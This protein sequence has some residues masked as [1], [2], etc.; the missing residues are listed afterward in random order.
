MAAAKEHK[1]IYNV[2]DVPVPYDVSCRMS[3]VMVPMRDGVKLHTVIYF[4]PDFDGKPLPA[5][6]VRS[7][8]TR[9]TYFEL[10]DADCLKH[11]AI[12][13]L[14]A[15]RGTGW[16]EGVFDPAEADTEMNDAADLLEYLSAQNFFNGNCVMRGASYP[17]W[18][19]WS[20]ARTGHPALKGITPGVAPLYSCCGS[21]FLG[22]GVLWLFTMEW[23]LTM[24]H[25]VTYGYG[26]V[27][28]Y[29][30]MDIAS[31]LPEIDADLH[32]GYRE[33]APVRKFFAAARHPAEIMQRYQ[34]W[35][36]N[37]TIPA[38]IY[39]GWFDPFKDQT[40]EGFML[41]VRDAAA[42]NA[43]KFTRLT[44][45]P[46]GHGGLLNPEVF[47]KE[48]DQKNM[49]AEMSKFIFGLLKSPAEDPLPD[50]PAVRFYMMGENRWYDA[51]Q[52]PPEGTGEKTAYLHSNG[53]ANS[54]D[55]DGWIDFTAPAGAEEPDV[56]ISD[57]AHP[58]MS[59][60]GG[61]GAGCYDRSGQQKNSAMLVY[62]SQVFS[63]PLA[64]T[65]EVKFSFYASASTADTDF[66]AHLSLLMP[67][68]RALRIAN[69]MV[70]ARYRNSLEAPE[71]LEPNKVY[72]FE[73]SLSHTALKIMPGQALRLDICG[74]DFPVYGRNANSGKELLSDTVLYLSR[75][76]ILHDAEH[77]AELHLPVNNRF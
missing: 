57:P 26:A 72:R 65:G 58:V 13:V 64:I 32:A 75:H 7:P 3:V 70:R 62:T 76:T 56:Y 43:R 19:Q 39:G 4:P 40:I 68:G 53:R 2:T 23:C 16:S 73:I 36:K 35:F 28:N 47:G 54:S 49:L 46:W 60:P 29:R 33:L 5:V 38:F 61:S 14:Q 44:I 71:L 48:C 12:Y 30:E 41:M 9:K 17:G 31:K 63:A 42:E 66:V 18:C 11:G 22:G 27:P 51:G 45:G 67:D 37:F 55:G 34:S 15:C 6:V 24:H 52:W 50:A 8:Y 69:G 20:A 1:D 10:P 25:R 77:P 21:S 74:Q 59:F